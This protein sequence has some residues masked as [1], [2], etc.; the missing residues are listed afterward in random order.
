MVK[1][2]DSGDGHM[3]LWFEKFDDISLFQESINEVC[4]YLN[5]KYKNLDKNKPILT[6]LNIDKFNTDN[7]KAMDN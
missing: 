7:Y 5:N 4:N 6:K 2:I 1:W 3:G